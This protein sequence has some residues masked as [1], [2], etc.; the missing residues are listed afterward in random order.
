MSHDGS[1]RAACLIR[2]WIL[3]LHFETPSVARGVTAPGVGSGALFGH[4]LV[5]RFDDNRTVAIAF[6]IRANSQQRRTAAMN[7]HFIALEASELSLS[8]RT[9]APTTA[10]VAIITATPT[11]DLARSNRFSF[12]A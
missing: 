2:N 9:P 5:H 8:E 3:T 6:A 4:F 1:W 7:G 10:S 11:T 12:A